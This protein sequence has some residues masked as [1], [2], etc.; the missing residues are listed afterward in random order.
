M[1]DIVLVHLGKYASGHYRTW[2]L[3]T[4][5][6]DFTTIGSMFHILLFW[7]S[8]KLSGWFILLIL[9]LHFYIQSA[10]ESTGLFL[11]LTSLKSFSLDIAK[12]EDDSAGLFFFSRT[13]ITF[14]ILVWIFYCGFTII[15]M[16]VVLGGGGDF[17]I[18]KPG[19]WVLSSTIVGG[20]C[21]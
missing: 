19:W 20:Q 14:L 15:T 3:F 10:C 12:L 17:L 21:G 16:A 8:Q 6:K 1:P 11:L 9:I 2:H 13:L 18:Q 4:H 5:M 7:F